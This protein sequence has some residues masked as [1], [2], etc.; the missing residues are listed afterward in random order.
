MQKSPIYRII[1][2]SHNVSYP[3]LMFTLLKDFKSKKIF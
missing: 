3:T 2:T 1:L